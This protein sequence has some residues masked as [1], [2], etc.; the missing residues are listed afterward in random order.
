MNLIDNVWKTRKARINMSER[1]KM[2]DF[3]SQILII[4]YS[5]LLIVITIIDMNNN[6]IDVSIPTLILSI[7]I[8]VISIFIYAMNFKQRSLEMQ[9]SYISMQEILNKLN[10]LSNTSSTE[11]EYFEILKSTE[12]HSKC[13]HLK[14]LYEV[15][16][17]KESERLNGKFTWSMIFQFYFC[18]LKNWFLIITLFLLPIFVYFFYTKLYI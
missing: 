9:K 4:Y 11:K 5:L 3:Y 1:L 18:C 8:L 2:Y 12:N 16:K 14:V 7:V 17:Q 13:D 10:R 15:R 6:G